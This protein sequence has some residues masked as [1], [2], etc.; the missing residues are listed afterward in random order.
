MCGVIRFVSCN[1][2]HGSGPITL[3]KTHDIRSTPMYVYFSGLDECLRRTLPL[4]GESIC[5]VF[6]SMIISVRFLDPS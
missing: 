2:G 3:I 1:K 5:T 6:N 4:I